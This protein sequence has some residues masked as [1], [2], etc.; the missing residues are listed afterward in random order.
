M[1]FSKMTGS[2]PIQMMKQMINGKANGLTR[3]ALGQLMSLGL[4]FTLDSQYFSS[5]MN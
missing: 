5:L 1:L 3:Q 4:F 2:K